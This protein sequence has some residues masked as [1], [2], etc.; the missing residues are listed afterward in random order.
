MRAAS[1]DFNASR[2]G[3]GD[4][5]KEEDTEEEECIAVD[6]EQQKNHSATLVDTWR[7]YSRSDDAAHGDDGKNVDGRL[8]IDHATDDIAG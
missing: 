3:F 2:G 8:E 4:D 1:L 7:Q 5:D 6:D